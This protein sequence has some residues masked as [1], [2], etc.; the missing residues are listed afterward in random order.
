MFFPKPQSYL[1]AFQFKT[2]Q[3]GIINRYLREKQGWDLHLENSK[4]YIMKAM[5]GKSKNC[6]CILGSGW[7]LDV[8]IDELSQQFET[9][10]LVDIVH[11][12]QI[13]HRIKKMPNVV[14]IVTDISGISEQI[15]T[16]AN[17]AKKRKALIPLE[18]L[19]FKFSNFGLPKGETPDFVV[20]VNLLNQLD[21]LITDYLK[22]EK[23]GSDVELQNLKKTIQAFHYSILP[24]GKTCLITDYEELIYSNT[25]QFETQNPLVHIPF[26]ESRNHEYWQWHFDSSGMYY[27]NKMTVFNVVALEK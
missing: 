15:F 24:Q 21:I 11:P 3:N 26:Q 1:K 17:E 16:L 8:P 7:L 23:I 25:K 22:K 10:Y 5:H 20:S 12:P 4:A 6:T 13:L 14:P 18:Q 9:V 19:D 27:K 2:D